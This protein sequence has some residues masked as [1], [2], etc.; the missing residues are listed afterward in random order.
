MRSL[1]GLE[2]EISSRIRVSTMYL[3]RY[4]QRKQFKLEGRYS[5]LRDRGFVEPG[6]AY[7]AERLQRRNTY[8]GFH[9]RGLER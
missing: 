5:P 9:N 4:I 1:I 3:H 8:N 7:N 6:I 2:S